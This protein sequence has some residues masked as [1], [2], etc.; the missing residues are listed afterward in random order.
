MIF[1][2]KKKKKKKTGFKLILNQLPHAI[3]YLSDFFVF[4]MIITWMFYIINGTAAGWYSIIVNCDTTVFTDL[5]D[6]CTIPLMTGGCMWLLKCALNHYNSMR[7]NGKRLSADFPNDDDF[8]NEDFDFG[9]IE[10]TDPEEDEEYFEDDPS[11]EDNDEEESNEEDSNE[12]DDSEEESEE[13]FEDDDSSLEDEDG[14]DEE[15]KE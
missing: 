8:E 3:T 1:G 4:L 2:K 11:V 6:A 9:D 7:Q 13:Y 12:D 10:D 14:V 15:E 5:K